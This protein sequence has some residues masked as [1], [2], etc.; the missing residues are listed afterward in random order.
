MMAIG[1]AIAG[2]ARQHP[3]VNR[4]LACGITMKWPH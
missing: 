1:G 4:R 3:G 2:G